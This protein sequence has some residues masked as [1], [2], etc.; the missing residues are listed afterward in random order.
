MEDETQGSSSEPK[1]IAKGS[2]AS[3]ESKGTTQ[4][5]SAKETAERIHRERMARGE[6][7]FE[8]GRAKLI[9]SG[10]WASL[11][12]T[13]DRAAN[14]PGAYQRI[15]N[16]DHE[17]GGEEP[18]PLLAHV[19]DKFKNAKPTAV[20][21]IPL[22]QRLVDPSSLAEEGSLESAPSSVQTGNPDNSNEDTE[23]QG[24]VNQDAASAPKK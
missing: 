10:E 18:S 20:P 11:R 1:E 24:E 8:R 12:A 15:F 16:N 14:A 23:M 13:F 4:T 19:R 9:A 2:E 7:V 22:D 17:D 6:E 5:P 21:R 3:P